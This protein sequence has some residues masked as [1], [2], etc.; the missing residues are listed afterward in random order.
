M[1]PSLQSQDQ[2]AIVRAEIKQGAH[3]LFPSQMVDASILPT[4][5]SGTSKSFAVPTAALINHQS[6]TVLF[7]QTKTG[8]EVRE[9]KVLSAQGESSAVTGM[10]NGT[11]NIAISGTA[12]IKASL[13]GMG[14]AE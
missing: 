10:F 6:R 12:A 7:V 9:V 1:L 11:E 13:Q 8:F 4:T 5:V 2:A 14:G 3:D